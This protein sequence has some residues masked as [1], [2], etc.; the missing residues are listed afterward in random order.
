MVSRPRGTPIIS[1]GVLVLSSEDEDANGILDLV[2]NE[3]NSVPPT[4]GAEKTPDGLRITIT[5]MPGITCELQSAQD[6][7]AAVWIKEQ[8]VTLTSDQV[9][10][11]VPAAESKRFFR[12]LVE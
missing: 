2:E 5:A 1:I 6:L 4:L 3:T 7:A 10:L 8:S 12:V 11:A 9:S